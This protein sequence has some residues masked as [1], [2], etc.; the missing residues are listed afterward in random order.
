MYSFQCFNTCI[1]NVKRS[2]LAI[3]RPP[4]WSQFMECWTSNPKILCSSPSLHG[5]LQQ[6]CVRRFCFRQEC[7]SL[8]AKGVLVHQYCRL[9]SVHQCCSLFMTSSNTV[10]MTGRSYIN[11]IVLQQ[12][13]AEQEQTNCCCRGLSF[14]CRW[15]RV[16]KKNSVHCEILFSA[17]QKYRLRC[18]TP[19]CKN[20]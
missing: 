9:S 15:I 13:S 17:G 10:R 11:E 2:K 6:T 5:S 16:F 3:Q 7:C 18:L 8:L 14:C 4:A 19:R 1:L 12:C 20:Y